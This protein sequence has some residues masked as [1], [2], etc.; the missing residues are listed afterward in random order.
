MLRISQVKPL[1]GEEE[2]EAAAQ[3]VRENWITEGPKSA[4]FSRRLN[5]LIGV[6]FGVF[7]PNGTL[8]LALGLMALGIKHGDE[9]L[10]PDTTFV[11]SATAAVMVGAVPVFVDVDPDTFQLDVESAE[12][13]VTARTRAIMPVH[14]Y[15]TACNMAEVRR[16]AE[17]HDLQIIEDAAQG[18]G[19]THGG[20]HVGSQG[21]VGCFSFFADKTITT[22]EGGYVVCRD[23]S[24]FDRLRALR[25]QG[26]IDRGSF[27]HPEIGYNFRTT[28]IQSAIGLVQLGKL[29][30]IIERKTEIF[31]WYL[32]LLQSV[33][34]VRILGASE[35]G[36]HVPFR[37]VLIADRAQDLTR[38]LEASGVQTRG[39]FYPL[40]RQP[41]FYPGKA[42]YQGLEHP[43]SLDDAHFPRAN[44]GYDHGVCLPI[45]PGLLQAEVA[46]IAN[47]II[48]FYA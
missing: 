3:A 30:S 25:N 22:G 6:E 16:F 46:Y 13:F 31:G 34:Q 23:A 11:G 39:F 35:G 17:R 2:A 43:P 18:I 38:H 7:A 12:K 5:D 27:I 14:L 20:K 10:I 24:T 44:H 33:P 41:C 36:S 29:P 19:V 45:Y 40:H 8:A 28:D 15:G 4:E 32:D 48:D 9:V 37:C 1:L 21:D 26:R 42:W 47:Q